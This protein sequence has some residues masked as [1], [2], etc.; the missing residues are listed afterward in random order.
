MAIPSGRNRKR[1][2]GRR[3][4]FREPK[5]KLLIVCEGAKTEKQY[6]E[7]FAKFHRQTRQFR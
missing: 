7:Q 3:A 6:F 4:P 1:R 2:S 5:T